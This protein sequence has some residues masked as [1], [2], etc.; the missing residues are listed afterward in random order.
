M[1]QNLRD[2]YV[3]TD[4]TELL[5]QIGQPAKSLTP[6]PSVVFAFTGQG[7]QYVRM[8]GTLYRTSSTFRRMLDLCQRLCDA[9]GLDCHILGTILGSR[10]AES[11]D[12]TNA[13]R[14]I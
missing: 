1:H 2:A 3:A 5:H 10:D 12:M 9:Q 11:E 4:I 8:G 7:S 6:A 13:V 14:D